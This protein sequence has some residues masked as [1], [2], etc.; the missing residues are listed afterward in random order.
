MTGKGTCLVMGDKRC[1]SCD[2]ERDLP[3]DG[4][5]GLMFVRVKGTCLVM[6]DQRC[7]SWDRERDLPC[8]RR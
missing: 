7:D 1:D 2:R 6:V 3:C 5:R 4:I 8:D